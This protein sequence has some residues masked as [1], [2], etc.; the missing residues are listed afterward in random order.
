MKKLSNGIV[1]TLIILFICAQFVQLSVITLFYTILTAITILISLFFSKGL[2]KIFGIIMTVIG[3][4]IMIYQQ[5]PL[6]GWTEAL[7][8]NL[9]LICLIIIVPI[10]GTPIE[11]GKYHQQIAGFTVRFRQK[12]QFLYLF[13]SGLFWLIAPITNVGSIYIIDAMLEK[14]NLPNALLGRV[15]V[16]GITAV[17]TWSPYFASVFLVVYSL[18]IPIYQYLPYGLILSFFQVLTAYLIFRYIEM[19]HVDFNSVHYDA[20]QNNKKLIELFL[21]IVFI[22]GFIFILE[23]VIDINVSALISLIVLS[24]A[25]VWAVYLRYTKYFL[26]ELNKYLFTIFPNR[27]NEINLLLSAG[28]FGVVLSD[29]PISGY[30]NDMWKGLASISIFVLILTTI[31]IISILSFIGVHQIVTISMVVA[32]VSYDDLGIHVIIMAMMLLSAWAVSTTLSPVS[33]IMPIVS[34]LL[35]EN[36][37]KIIVRWNLLYAITLTLIHTVIIYFTHLLWFS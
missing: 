35:K 29:T 11:L 1:A 17:H 31:I 30:I 27:A 14:L 21:A 9:P 12:P 19:Y 18:Q 6:D 3:S 24:C 16:R 33:P 32:T 25:L 36:I 10:L 8:K 5:H 20:Q 28:F 15:Y 2:P 34:G 13:I 7:T 26:K 23:P 22:T 4:I 37:Y